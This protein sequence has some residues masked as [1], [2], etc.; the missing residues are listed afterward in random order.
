MNSNLHL[1][2]YID[3]QKYLLV[4]KRRWKPSL[5]IFSS[6]VGLS[7]VAALSL[8][9]IYE[10]EAQL[11]IKVDRS[12]TLTGL[13]NGTGEIKGLTTDSNP[14]S[15]EAEVL[16]SRPIIK[17]LIKELDLK[18]DEGEP[19]KYKD[20]ADGF[21]VKP[22]TGTDILEIT[23]IDEEPEFAAIVVNKA[24]ELYIEDHTLNNRS[25]TASAR[26]FIDNQ[27]PEVEKKVRKAEA[28][29]RDFKNQNRIASLAEETTANVDSIST[30]ANRIDEVEANLESINARYNRLQT[31][32]NM[33]WEEA[34]AVSALS[35][36]LAVQR[37]SEQLQ[38]VK[39]VLARKRN[40]LSDNAPQII[41]LKEEETDLTNLLN[42]QIAATIGSEQQNII[43]KVNI[44]SLGE[45][46]QEQI[47]EFSNLGLRKEGLEK[48]LAA[49]N[50]TYESY[51]QKSDSLPQLQEQERELQRQVGAAQSTYQTLLAK[52]QETRITEQQNIGN[53]RIVSE[54]DVPDEAVGPRKK[55]IVGGAG[56]VGAFLAVAGAFLLDIRDKT[57]K[58]TEEIKR[59]LPYAL[60]G[61]IPDLNKINAQKQLLLPDSSTSSLPQVAVAHISTL[62]AREAYHNI[63]INLQLLD[64][65]IENKVIV[66]SSAVSGE[67]KSSVSANLALAQAQC[68][69]R[70]LL[71]DG[72]LRRPNQHNLWEL[73]NDLGLTEILEQE[74]EWSDALQKVMPNLDVI[75]SGSCPNHP[76]SLLNSAFMKA[77]II[78]ISSRYDCI[79]IDTPPLVGLA[80]SK[81]LAKLSDGL[82]FVVRPKRVNYSSIKAARELLEN[83]DL[84]LLGIIANGVDIDQ[85]PYDHGYYYAD[86]KYL[87]AAG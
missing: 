68:N 40:H 72:D 1:D 39:I 26:D 67:G 5:A 70:V 51:K 22:I 32:L 58:N 7:I 43:D 10:A 83:Q 15:T 45:L 53:V 71:V 41:S 61:V 35:Q 60:T 38:E 80:D 13:E 31:Q 77:F 73:S 47:A 8:E 24:I 25:E 27:L 12:A 74:V 76:I 16:K 11:L 57:I 82:L 6:I 28:N 2:E 52:L 64:S 14:L 86:K 50:K 79:I 23:Y 36:S 21:K 66:V 17:K 37:V 87:E 18:N 30:I 19:L 42:R 3:F 78:S 69:K 33:S 56:V 65:E 55:I 59:L 4:L 44:F 34:S 46:K 84:N 54:A 81:I 48:Q 20:V 9:K 85:E 75:T 63:Q 29:L 62:P 49:L